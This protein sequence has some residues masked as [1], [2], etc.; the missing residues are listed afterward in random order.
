M[1]SGSTN[2]SGRVFLKKRNLSSISFQKSYM[3]LRNFLSFKFLGNLI[4]NE[5]YFKTIAI[6]ILYIKFLVKKT[7]ILVK[8]EEFIYKTFTNKSNFQYYLKELL[9]NEIIAKKWLE[10]SKKG[11]K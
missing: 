8:N 1:F 10:E 7:G 3:E 4:K 6:I 11:N 5:S 9:E 2:F